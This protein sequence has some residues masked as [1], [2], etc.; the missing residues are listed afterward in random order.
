MS[1]ADLGIYCSETVREAGHVYSLIYS[2]HVASFEGA[3]T[4][5]QSTFLFDWTYFAVLQK[6]QLFGDLICLIVIDSSD[7]IT[8]HFYKYLF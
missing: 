8:L 3:V 5:F 6:K 2:T 4:D 7:K 1:C